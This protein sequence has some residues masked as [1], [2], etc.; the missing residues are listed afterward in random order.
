MELEITGSIGSG[1]MAILKITWIRGR[2][3]FASEDAPLRDLSCVRSN[4]NH[5]NFVTRSVA[6][7][8]ATCLEERLTDDGATAGALV[9]CELG[10]IEGSRSRGGCC[11]RGE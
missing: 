4:W 1:N 5:N 11:T 6:N 9:S 7:F 3:V 10:L 8:A 2:E